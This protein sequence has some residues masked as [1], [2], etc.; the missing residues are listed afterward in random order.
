VIYNPE[1]YA[2]K[3]F[4]SAVL[5]GARRIAVQGGAPNKV[6]AFQN[7]DGSRVLILSNDAKQTVSTTISVG[8]TV[9]QL[10]LPALSMN[11]IIMH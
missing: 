11:T 7:T 10:D 3:H 4:S 2:M 8:D 9:L 6:V 1:F 5:P